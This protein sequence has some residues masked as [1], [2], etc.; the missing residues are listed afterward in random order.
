MI[1][2]G[3]LITIP[4]AYIQEVY[5]QKYRSTETF[6]SFTSGVSSRS[7]HSLRSPPALTFSSNQKRD[8]VLQMITAL[9][10]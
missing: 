6:A 10:E 4:L 8:V 1:P 5:L 7:F 2:E 3:V 9:T